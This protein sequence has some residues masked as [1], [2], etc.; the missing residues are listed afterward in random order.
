MSWFSLSLTAAI[1]LAT[2][3]A[4]TKKSL[5]DRLPYEMG[6]VRLVCTAPWLL[7]VLAFI[8]L[9]TPDKTFLFCIL[10]GI[11]LEVVAFLCYMRALKASPLSLSLPFLAFTPG[12]MILTG[13]I[14]LG[15]RISMTGLTGI[16]LI[17]IGAYVLNLSEVRTDLLGPFRAI[18]REPGSRF[19]L[20]TAFIY[21]FTAPIGK[22]GTLHSNPY[23]FGV[24]Y[25]LVLTGSLFLLLPFFP[26]AR[27]FKIFHQR[28]KAATLLGLTVSIEVFSHYLAIALVQA[29]YMI[30]I[31]RTSLLFGVLYG[32]L[33]FKEKNIGE[34]LTG[35][36]I[37]LAGV[38]VIG[39]Y[40]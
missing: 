34:R 3:D 22:L 29:A 2:C 10:A 4:I 36:I 18:F 40:G 31:K 24:I 13:W 17:I 23:F 27:P 5:G 6:M 32:A 38:F 26:G 37:M 19:M 12:F 21:S 15:E 35:A 14:I 11:P 9:V 25:N 33:W 16:L 7:L 30:S 1:S 8:P 39:M 20:A 28:P